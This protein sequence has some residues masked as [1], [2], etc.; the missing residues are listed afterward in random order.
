MVVE[1]APNRKYGFG[2][3]VSPQALSNARKKE[4]ILRKSS[5]EKDKYPYADPL[6]TNF[7]QEVSNLG[8]FEIINL[9]VEG[10]K[11]MDKSWRIRRS[12]TAIYITSD[13]T[14]G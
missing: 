7:L 4:E 5:K 10:H 2:H 13:A 11:G 1:N 6:I 14:T 9:S 8:L 3:E 12:V